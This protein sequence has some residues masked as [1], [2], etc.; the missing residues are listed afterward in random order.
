MPTFHPPTPTP[1]P[2]D[3]TEST[4]STLTTS[5]STPS[6]ET[7]CGHLRCPKPR[8][9]ATFSGDGKPKQELP[10]KLQWLLE[11]HKK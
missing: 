8:Y 3:E 5:S 11:G 9:L 4:P 6:T 2:T 7:P 10:E 1:S